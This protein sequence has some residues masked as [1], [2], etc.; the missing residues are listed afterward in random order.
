MTQEMDFIKPHPTAA[1]KPLIIIA[2]PTAVGKTAVSV[3]VAR[4]MHGECISAD[5]VQIYQGLDIGSA[6]VTRE[7]MQ[8]VPHHLIDVIPPTVNY[9]A[10]M[11]QRM[12]GA[13]IKDVYERK[14]IPILV[15]GTGFYIQGLLYGIDFTEEPSEEQLALRRKLEEQAALPGGPEKLYAELMRVDPASTVK[16]HAHNVRRVIRALEFYHLH[17]TP[18]SRHNA[19]E[20]KKSPVYDSMFFVLTDD[21]EA[22][23]Q[24]INKRVDLMMQ[25]GLLDEVRRLREMGLDRS[26]TSM[27]GI[28]YK[29]LLEYLDGSISLEDAVELIKKHSRNYAKRQL[30]WFRRERDVIWVNIK[31][32]D[33]KKDSIAKWIIEKCMNQ[34]G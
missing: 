20:R 10:A 26:L 2:G 16:I 21:R 23:Y 19:E 4:A 3:A 12:A 14:H 24:R 7:E 25:Q 8:G 29:E 11:F 27:Q 1:E 15:G 17:G 6:K 34:W 9:D 32:F 18:I 33:Y 30:T 31:D 28:G 5:S 13:A 22:L